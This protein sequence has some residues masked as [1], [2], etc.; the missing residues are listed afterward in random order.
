MATKRRNR[1]GVLKSKG[2]AAKKSAGRTE[3]LDRRDWTVGK[4]AWN[5]D[6]NVVILDPKLAKYLRAKAR[7]DRQIEMGIPH[8]PVEVGRLG[9]SGTV[10]DFGTGLVT[11][12]IG[13]KLPPP[14][15]LCG[16][17]YLH[18]QLGDEGPVWH[19]LL[20]HQPIRRA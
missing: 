8:L 5:K 20:S 12:T 16:C 4:I 17:D 19:K 15:T 7:K 6:G 3:I 18:F 2:S 10:A 9:E 13:Q 11:T 1:K 14:L